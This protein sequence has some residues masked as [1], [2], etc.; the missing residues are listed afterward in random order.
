MDIELQLAAFRISAEDTPAAFAFEVAAPRVEWAEKI[1]VSI[2]A[3][4]MTLLIQW[5]IVAG[6]TGL[7][8]FRTEMNS[9]LL[10]EV[11]F[12]KSFDL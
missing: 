8:G 9:G 6:L 1:W 4:F 10:D 3:A 5:P 2:P 11:G 7:C 12:L